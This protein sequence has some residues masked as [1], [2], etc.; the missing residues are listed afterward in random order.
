M[1]LSPTRPVGAHRDDDVGSQRADVP[2]EIA[3]NLLVAP[4]LERFLLAERVAEVH[5]ACE[6][7]LGAVE[8]M[9]GEQFFG[10]EDA[11]GVKELGADLVL[12]AV[13]A[14]GRH[15]RHSRADVARVEG[16]R[17]IVLVVGVRGH[18]NDRANGRELSQGERQ[19]GR[20]RQVG[21]RLDAI[22]GDGLLGANLPLQR[23]RR[24]D[25]HG[26]ESRHAHGIST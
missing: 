7:L 11:Q 23:G 8:A 20:A 4:L 10:A 2:D 12:A 19:G 15:E 9:R 1:V 17:R 26:Q 22:L 13:A 6:V 24:G 5:G 21:Q 3:E 14:G 16:Q 18:V 25:R